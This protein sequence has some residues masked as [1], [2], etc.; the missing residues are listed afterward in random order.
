VIY[1][2]NNRSGDSIADNQDEKLSHFN[3]WRIPFRVLQWYSEQDITP[4]G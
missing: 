2:I 4:G 1:Q 3:G